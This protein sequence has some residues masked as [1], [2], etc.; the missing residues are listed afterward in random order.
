MDDFNHD[1]LSIDLSAPLQGA[2]P[3]PPLPPPGTAPVPGPGPSPGPALLT[4]FD[5]LSTPYPGGPTG[6]GSGGGPSSDPAAPLAPREILKL[7][8]NRLLQPDALPYLRSVCKNMKFSKSKGSELANL[9]KLIHFYKVWAH[10][11]FPRYPYDRFVERTM[12]VCRTKR[13]KGQMNQWIREELEALGTYDV[14]PD[15]D[16]LGHDDS[17]ETTTPKD[18]DKELDEDRM[19]V[20]EPLPK[21]APDPPALPSPSTSASAAT[22]SSAASPAVNDT[23]KQR[24]LDRLAQLKQ[25]RFRRP[26]SPASL[27]PLLPPLA[28]SPAASTFSPLPALPSSTATSSASVTLATPSVSSSSSTSARARVIVDD[29]DDDDDLVIVPNDSASAAGEQRANASQ[30]AGMR[31]FDD[32]ASDEDDAEVFGSA[33]QEQGSFAD[34]GKDKDKD[35]VIKAAEMG[36]SASLLEGVDVDALFALDDEQW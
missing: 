14:D 18:K 10:R 15:A 26:M 9:D 1:W 11:V 33:A 23:A 3:P 20:D 30:V 36:L 17:G 22:G 34:T 8:D 29:S 25:S 12:R 4:G 5:P 28:T 21:P 27:P 32:M 31:V 6:N 13:V 2:P 24:A 19:D 7:D 16:F 35:N